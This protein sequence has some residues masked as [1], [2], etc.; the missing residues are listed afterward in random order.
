MLIFSVAMTFAGSF[1]VPRR[2]WDI[3]FSQAPF[4]VEFS[5]AVD[6]VIGVMALGGLLAVAG[7]GIYILVTVASVFFGRRLDA[8]ESGR[9]AA[10]KGLPLGLISPP[11]ALVA[12]DEAALAPHALGV[13]PGTMVLVGVFLV[14]FVTYYFVN[15]KLLSVVWKVG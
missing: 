7:G 13:A 15:W 10:A 9:G 12:G 5:P 14:A 3:T 11:R 1:G 6:L 8:A 4:G 2:H